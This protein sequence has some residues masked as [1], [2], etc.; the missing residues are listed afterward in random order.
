MAHIIGTMLKLKR[1]EMDELELLATLHDIGKL[2][3]DSRILQKA[4]HLDQDEWREMKKH[5]EIGFRI[6]MSIHELAPIAE[7]ILYHH[8]R[9][10]GDGYPHGLKGEEIPLLSRILAVI[11]AYDAMTSDRIYRHALSIEEAVQELK[12]HAGS[13]F[14]PQLVEIFI[15]EMCE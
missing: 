10:D 8:E 5:A 15:S 13:Q 1:T 4:G 11:D 7:Y 6:A 12:N 14:D 3:V 2:G 9:W